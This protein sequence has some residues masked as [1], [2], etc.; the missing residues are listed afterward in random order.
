MFKKKF[1]STF[2]E[3]KKKKRIRKRIQKYQ[4]RNFI[5]KKK[6]IFHAK[7]IDENLG[8]TVKES[9]KKKFTTSGTKE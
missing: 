6:K 1:S 9:K 7:Y 3:L 5:Q 4:F 8:K 2:K